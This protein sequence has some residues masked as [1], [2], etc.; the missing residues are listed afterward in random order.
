MLLCGYRHLK[1]LLFVHGRLSLLRS[2]NVA[3]FSFYKN[4][5][6]VMP[7]LWFGIHSGYTGTPL[8][9][10]LIMSLYNTLFTSIPP[11]AI[12]LFEQDVPTSLIP[13]NASCVNKRHS[14]VI[15]TRI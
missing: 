2:G 12:G 13:S 4:S 8:Y 15:G 5:C 11:L 3:L 7:I 1:N 6:F 9:Y 14:N 10:P